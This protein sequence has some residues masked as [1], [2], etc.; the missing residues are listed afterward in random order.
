MR[1]LQ[2]ITICL[3]LV[4]ALAFSV[5]FCYDRMMVDHVAPQIICDGAKLEVSVTASEAELCKGLIATDDVDGD[6]TDRIIVRRVS[7]L[8]GAN[9]AMV[10]YAV[11]DS[12]SN[13]CTFTREVHYTDYHQPRFSLSQPMIYHVGQIISL[14]DRL[15]AYDAIDGDISARIRVSSVNITNTAEGEY[16]LTLQVTNTTGDTAVLSLTVII[17]NYTSY[18]PVIHLSNYITYVDLG[19]EVNIE[20]FRDQIVSARETANGASVSADDIKITGYVDTSDTGCYDVTF[21]YT[22]S[23][24]LS[25]DVILT[26]IVQ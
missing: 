7:R 6:I 26:V 9:T 18:H 1:N 15:T 13:F 5:L 19:S 4:V 24:D 21:S 25:Y 12:A 14:D 23:H 11:F 10:Y 8:I 22:N 16:P 3:F 2:I 17:K 20:D